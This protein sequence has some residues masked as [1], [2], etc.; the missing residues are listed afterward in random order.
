MAFETGG[1]VAAKG[2]NLGTPSAQQYEGK[3][4][5]IEYTLLRSCHNH[6]A[7]RSLHQLFMGVQWLNAAGLS[8][9]TSNVVMSYV[10]TSCV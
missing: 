3:D 6:G 9:P 1:C 7:S 4:T 2:A 8:E 10:D 5:A